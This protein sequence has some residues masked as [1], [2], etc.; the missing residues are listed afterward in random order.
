[1]NRLTPEQCEARYEAL[2]EAAEHLRM[3]W[4]DCEIEIEEGLRI[5]EWLDR[6]ADYW[7]HQAVDRDMTEKSCLRGQDVGHL[8]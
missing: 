7:L 5:A 8:R 4:T 1:M 2:A 3:T 6:K